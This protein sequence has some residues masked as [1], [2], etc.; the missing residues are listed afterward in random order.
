MILSSDYFRPTR[1]SWG[2]SDFLGFHRRPK[3]IYVCLNSGLRVSHWRSST[4]TLANHGPPFI[5]RCIVIVGIIWE[6]MTYGWS[7]VSRHNWCRHS[8]TL[9][10]KERACRNGVHITPSRRNY[11]STA[12]T[13]MVSFRTEG[14]HTWKTSLHFGFGHFG[15]WTFTIE[16][17]ILRMSFLLHLYNLCFPHTSR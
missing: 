8:L 15:F 14:R 16:M 5:H 3:R 12:Q 9:T 11:R 2:Y 4:P 10:T 13:D 17:K 6:K 1:Q 7:G